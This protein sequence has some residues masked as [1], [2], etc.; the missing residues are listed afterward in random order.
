MLGWREPH[1]LAL[2]GRSSCIG[3]FLADFCVHLEVKRAEVTELHGVAVADEFLHL[4]E[5]RAIHG[6]NLL[7]ADARVVAGHLDQLFIV[8]VRCT[9]NGGVETLL[10]VESASALSDFQTDVFLCNYSGPYYIAP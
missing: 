1:F 4:N 6:C 3:L 5:Q 2:H 9:A 8:D 10:L 7:D